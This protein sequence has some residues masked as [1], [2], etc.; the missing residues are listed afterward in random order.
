MNTR[1]CA[2]AVKW[3]RDVFY[4]DRPKTGKTYDEIDEEAQSAPVGSEGLLFHPYL[5][6]ED[7]P[8]WDS[9]LKGDFSGISINHERSHFA[10]VNL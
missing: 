7:A 2:Q 10:R 4:K 9:G 3:L 6:G 1:S 5:L 8:Y